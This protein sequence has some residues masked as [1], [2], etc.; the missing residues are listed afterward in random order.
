MHVILESIHNKPLPEIVKELVFE[1]LGMT[2]SFYM[3]GLPEGETNF[4]Q[5]WSTGVTETAPARWHIQPELGAAGVWTT[6]GDL[7]RAQRGIR[8]AALGRS[9]F[10]SKE[11][12]LKGLTAVEGASG[13][14]FGGWQSGKNWFGHGGANNPGFKCQTMA[15]FDYEGKRELGRASDEGIA[16]MTNSTLGTDV[17]HKIIQA[18]AYLRGWP[19]EGCCWNA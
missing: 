9:D 14:T 18:V 6:P 13:F 11:L 2:R 16:V 8:D 3:N 12:A 7:M 17:C 1:P 19:G 10:L 4:A 5:C 15:C